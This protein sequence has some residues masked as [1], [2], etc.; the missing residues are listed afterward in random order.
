M[1]VSPFFDHP[2]IVDVSGYLANQQIILGRV[3][4]YDLS[5][6]IQIGT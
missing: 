5:E 2:R 6:K 1:T 4:Q 3:K